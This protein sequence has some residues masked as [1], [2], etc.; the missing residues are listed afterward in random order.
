V[1]PNDRDALATGF[2]DDF[3]C[4]AHQRAPHVFAV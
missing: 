1:N 4:D 3:V 2:L